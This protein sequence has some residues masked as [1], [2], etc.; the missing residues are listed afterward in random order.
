VPV[1]MYGRL[2][3]SAAMIASLFVI[4]FPLT[5]ITLQYSSVLRVFEQQQRLKTS[6]SVFSDAFAIKSG[7]S[8]APN[9]PN[10]QQD[11]ITVDMDKETDASTKQNSPSLSFKSLMSAKRIS[12]KLSKNHDSE[13][14]SCQHGSSNQSLANGILLRTTSQTIEVDHNGEA[15]AGHALHHHH[16]HHQG[17]DVK[18]MEKEI[19]ETLEGDIPSSLVLHISSW[20]LKSEEDEL[21]KMKIRIRTEKDYRRFVSLLTSFQSH[22]HMN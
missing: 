18:E 13:G 21:L 2:V 22:N 17:V 6:D 8:L 15:R 20:H 11:H 10:E 16:H 4:A 19:D 7:Q 14:Q 3:V 9:Q 1:T 5:M 12:Q